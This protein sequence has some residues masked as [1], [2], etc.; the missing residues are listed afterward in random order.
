MAWTRQTTLVWRRNVALTHTS[1]PLFFWYYDKN[2]W[3]VRD[4]HVITVNNNSSNC[5][6]VLQ[7][8][9]PTVRQNGS[10]ESHC[11]R[12]IQCPLDLIIIKLEQTCVNAYDLLIILL[13]CSQAHFSQTKSPLPSSRISVSSG[14]VSLPHSSHFID[15][16]FIISFIL[17]TPYYKH[18]LI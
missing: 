1:H 7:A 9:W 18:N 3:W 4:K 6:E 14:K 2:C 16:V 8:V 13:L 10:S 12:D 5:L 15:C 11:N 17:T